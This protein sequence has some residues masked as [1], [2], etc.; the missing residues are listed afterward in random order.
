M[1]SG[2]YKRT[3][4]QLEKA[5]QNL[6]KKGD[7]RPPFSKGWKKKISESRKGKKHWFYGKKRLPFSEEA[8]LRMSEGQKGKKHSLKTRKK[9]SVSRRGKRNNLWRG[10]V[11]PLYHR[12]RTCFQS[13]QWRSDVFTRDQ[14]ICQ[15]CGYEKGKILEADH[16]KP[17]K[18]ILIE[19]DI[20][21][22][23][24]ALECVELWNINNGRTLC[25]KCHKIK[26]KKDLIKILKCLQKQ[27]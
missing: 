27:K 7:K 11:T 4:K 9:M 22:I 25:K 3:K 20:R 5:T 19:N 26:T 6:V 1:P 18:I 24:E 12:I 23:E 13:R 21:N 16:I 10:G 15:E 2:V 8:K 14:F 17:F